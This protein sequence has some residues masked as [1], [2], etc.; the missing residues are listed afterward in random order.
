MSNSW[1]D[2][3][4]LGR[5]S[6]CLG[7]DPQGTGSG[8]G[9][10]CVLERGVPWLLLL[11]R[12]GPSLLLLPRAPRGAASRAA[13]AR[14]SRREPAAGLDRG[15]T[16]PRCCCRPRGCKRGLW[17]GPPRR[18]TAGP[19]TKTQ[20]TRGRAPLR[21]PWCWGGP[22]LRASEGER[23]VLEGSQLRTLR[24]SDE[25][26]QNTETDRQTPP[27]GQV[28]REA[29]RRGA[30]RLAIWGPIAAENI[31]TNRCQTI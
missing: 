3:Q 5:G 27:K 15:S 16:P 17:K 4:Q 14:R 28:Y 24:P 19:R 21:I 9:A 22:W 11:L 29:L 1:G 10:L 23:A 20:Q 7:G 18:P 2:W 26:I 12:R 25:K 13:R 8:S 6:C 31:L 30:G